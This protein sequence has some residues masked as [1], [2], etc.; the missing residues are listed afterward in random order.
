MAKTRSGYKPSCEWEVYRRPLR[1]PRGTRQI[2]KESQTIHFQEERRDNIIYIDREGSHLLYNPLVRKTDFLN[3]CSENK[4]NLLTKV[5]TLFNDANNVFDKDNDDCLSLCSENNP[6]LLTRKDTFVNDV[7][8][9]FDNAYDD[10]DMSLN[11][12]GMKK[13]CQSNHN[14][15]YH[16]KYSS[17]FEDKM[18]KYDLCNDNA[19]KLN[20]NNIE[21]Q[22]IQASHC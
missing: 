3:L 8:N 20:V 4:F 15:K 1:T 5:D 22:L 16:L 21:Y 12:D 10:D 17:E 14:I 9:V 11:D 18:Y 19:N 7:Y 13:G 2:G 6:N